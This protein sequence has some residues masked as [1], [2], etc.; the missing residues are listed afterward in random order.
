MRRVLSDQFADVCLCRLNYDSTSLRADQNSK[1]D[2]SAAG[3]STI[4]RQNA[5]RRPRR[6]G[7]SGGSARYARSS[8]SRWP[9]PHVLE[10]LTRESE[11]ELSEGDGRSPLP[12]PPSTLGA[13]HWESSTSSPGRQPGHAFQNVLRWSSL[14]QHMRIP[15]EVPDAFWYGDYPQPV[16]PPAPRPIEVSGPRR[17]SLTPRFAPAYP[18]PGEV[19][20]RSNTAS[21]AATANE[22]AETMPLLRRVGHRSVANARERHPSNHQDVDGLGD[23][24]RSPGP[25][26]DEDGVEDGDANA[27][28]E[29][30]ED[31]IEN[32]DEDEDEMHNS[33]ETL[34]NT[35]TPDDHLPSRDSSFT[36]ATATASSALSRNS[37]F[38]NPTTTSQ[39]PLTSFGP[40]SPGL[41]L[42]YSEFL[43][44]P[45]C[46][47]PISDSDS[48][49]EPES[50]SEATPG[51]PQSIFG[52][53]LVSGSGT[54]GT[55][56][57]RQGQRL[58]DSTGDERTPGTSA[59]VSFRTFSFPPDLQEVHAILDRLVRRDDIP[60]EWWA[61]AGLS[62]TIRRELNSTTSATRDD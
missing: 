22:S 36:S 32:E 18:V 46:E 62:R 47:F 7:V 55:E 3:R 51:L 21:P 59:N 39:T 10:A 12:N 42:S 56:R 23:R 19:S 61:T 2:P 53:P 25:D 31:G 26:E 57:E 45:H 44:G 16:A 6:N 27:N 49:T 48:D 13:A 20:S 34:L 8:S 40:D 14:A 4:R 58:D 33:W 29:E 9:L 24:E 41:R 17:P 5:V 60:E 54:R 30:D 43:P 28:V 52:F 37:A 11:R 15:N 1:P 50:D 38:S 35:I